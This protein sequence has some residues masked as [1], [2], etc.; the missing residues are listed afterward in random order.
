MSA[1]RN[2]F[3]KAIVVGAFVLSSAVVPSLSR[4]NANALPPEAAWF[5][6]SSLAVS[7]GSQVAL[8]WNGVPGEFFVLTS[9]TPA[10][11]PDFS[12]STTVKWPSGVTTSWNGNWGGWVSTASAA[13]VAIPDSATAGTTYDLQLDTCSSTNQLCS[14]SPGGSG[15]AQVALTVVANWSTKPYG[16][17]FSTTTVANGTGPRPLDVALSP[18]LSVWSTSEFSDGIG[19]VP[20]GSSEGLTFA[21]P[22][23]LALQPFAS[24]F[25][26][27][28]RCAP[29]SGSALSERVVM[30]NGEV[31]FTEGGWFLGAPT[32]PNHSEVVSSI[33]G[34]KRSARTSF[35]G[36]T[37]R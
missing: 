10:A 18:D 7:P 9:V 13:S 2:M 22:A 5:T 25:S 15:D 4:A 21:N 34:R 1:N 14:S 30:A 12:S 23:N 17:A 29:T 36:I 27:M 11:L 35:Q 16:D 26:S 37:T 3:I 33:R 8:H 28:S 20:S 32:V 19:E 24:C 6:M 31:W